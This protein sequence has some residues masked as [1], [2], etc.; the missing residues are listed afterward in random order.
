MAEQ[1]R[2]FRKALKNS[3]ILLPDGIGM[4]LALKISTGVTIPK[5]SG[6]ELH[7]HL[8]EK[9]NQEGGKCFYLGSSPATLQKI[10][11]RLATEYPH[12]KCEVYSPPFK[13]AFTE[14]ENEAMIGRINAFRPD[15]LFVGM[16]AP[17]QEKWAYTYKEAIDARYICS[18]G[19]VFDFYAGT[20]ERPGKFWINL[21]L[22][23]FIRLLKEPR[24]MWKR[25][26]LYGPLFIIMLLKEEVFAVTRKLA[27]SKIKKV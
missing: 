4:V 25:Y 5:I 8:L 3:D 15:A 20:L 21:G 7:E 23:W 14:E 18:I 2:D 10:V 12:I 6:S 13:E 19:A 16:T 22:E 26:L 9:L 11:N 1:D 24:R 17:K 27:Y